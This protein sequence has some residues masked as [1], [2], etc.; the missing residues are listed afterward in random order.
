LDCGTLKDRLPAELGCEGS[1]DHGDQRAIPRNVIGVLRKESVFEEGNTDGETK[2][3]EN[4][5]TIY[6]Q[7]RAIEKR[8]SVERIT[9]SAESFVTLVPKFS[10]NPIKSWPLG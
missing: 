2:Q 7:K 8:T 6:L 4:V 5:F 1:N 10:K 9:S 3:S